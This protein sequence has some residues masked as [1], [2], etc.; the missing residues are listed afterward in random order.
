MIQIFNR[1][2]YEDVVIQKVHKWVDDDTIERRYDHI[3]AFEKLIQENG[4]VILKFYLHVSPKEQLERLQERRAIAV[5]ERRRAAVELGADE[6]AAALPGIY[7]DL[8]S[9]DFA[10]HLLPPVVG[11]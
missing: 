1:S 8:P 2:H 4:T 11:W 10:R 3:N 9:L 5:G 7:R 6:R